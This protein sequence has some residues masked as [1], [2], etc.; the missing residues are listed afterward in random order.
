MTTEPKQKPLHELTDRELVWAYQ[1]VCDREI[2]Q[3]IRDLP[4]WGNA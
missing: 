3:R 1:A 2:E 4:T